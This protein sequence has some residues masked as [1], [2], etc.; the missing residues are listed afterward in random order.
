MKNKKKAS[1]PMGLL[2]IL[3]IVAIIVAV[4]LT[5]SGKLPELF[6]SASESQFDEVCCCK[7][8]KISEQP[9]NSIMIRKL[10]E[11]KKDF[12]VCEKKDCA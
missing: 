11:Q 8:I 3:L 6:K 2:V 10:C 1:M 5:W 4:S 12:K 7:T 9:E